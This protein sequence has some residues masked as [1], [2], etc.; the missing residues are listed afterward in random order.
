MTRPNHG[1]DPHFKDYIRQL[2]TIKGNVVSTENKQY[3]IFPNTHIFL[4]GYSQ[5][6]VHLKTKYIFLIRFFQ[7]GKKYGK[8]F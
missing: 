8:L 7:I 2:E 3:S 6:G 5:L 1:A 4:T